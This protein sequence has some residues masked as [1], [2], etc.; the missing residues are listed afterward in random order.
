VSKIDDDRG[1]MKMRHQTGMLVSMYL[2]EPGVYL[3]DFGKPVPED[4]AKQAGFDVER[5]GREKA[6][7]A[8]IAAA[9]AD[10]EADLQLDPETDEQKVLIERD[11]Y[12][13][14][15]AGQNMAMLVDEENNRLTP[16][17]LPLVEAEQLLD[18]LAPKTEEKA[19]GSKTANGKSAAKSKTG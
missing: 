3:N 5:L 10:I 15:A 9:M 6:K 12:K 19:D 14:I 7:R 13:M 4:I 16:V 1:V 2:D 17:P 18:S 11:G 8:R